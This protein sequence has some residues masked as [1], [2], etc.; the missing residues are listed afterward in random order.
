MTAAALAQR[1]VHRVLPLALVIALVATLH[2]T[3]SGLADARSQSPTLALGLLLVGGFIGGKASAAL[4]LPRITGYLL[5]GVI[6][7]PHLAGL[8]TSDMLSAAKAVEGVA[9]ALIALTAGGEL[10]VAW[11][12]QHAGR[13]ALITA[14][15]LLTVATVVTAA[16]FVGRAAFPFIPADLATAAVIAMVIGAIAVANSPTVTIAV[17][18]ETRSDGP[19][20]RTVL[21]VTILKDVTVI[22]LFAVA[23]VVAKDALGQG[24]GASLGATLLREIGG[25][26]AAG[27]AF[28]IGV[29]LFLRF[30]GRDVPVFVLAVCLAM[31]QVSTALHLETLLVALTAGFWV[32][33][34]GRAR[35]EALIKGIERVS[36][37]VYA[38]FFA[39]A[40]TKVDLGALEALW[41]LVLLLSGARGVAIWAGT[42]LGTRLARAEPVV[43]RY[44][45]LGFI[46]QA[47]VTLALA[48]IVAR[49]FPDWGSQV[50]ALM[51][52]MI[53]IHEL[54]GPIGF[55]WALARAGEIGRGAGGH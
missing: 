6:V 25:S 47:G 50:Q 8:L 3:A 5:T 48:G 41:P 1:L 14:T 42:R 39:A 37:P 15:E 23:L 44:L 28:G 19:L 13:L 18:A 29:E 2:A 16:V 12:R 26:A 10:R 22:I 43:R 36:L 55:Q 17:I 52:A 49:T 34:L 54:L 9:V 21:G 38:L 32:E 51:V 7:G 4:G 53:A 27:V 24:D 33:N 11:I 35:G 46:S 20:A 31:W 30:V 45:W 40:G